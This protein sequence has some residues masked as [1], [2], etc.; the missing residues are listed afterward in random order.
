MKIVPVLARTLFGKFEENKILP[1]LFFLLVSCC[2][3]LLQALNEKYETDV[4]FR[5]N[6][7]GLPSD[8]EIDGDD[9]Y[10]RVRL[11]DTGTEL[12]FYKVKGAIPV[13]VDFG[14]FG[15]RDGRLALPLSA[16]ERDVKKAVSAST[17]LSGMLQDTLFID[18]KRGTMMLPV[19]LDGVIDA[20]EGFSVADVEIIPSKVKV[21][22]TA[23]DMEGLNNVRTE[24]VIKKYLKGS[25]SFKADVA[26]FGLM[27]VEPGEVDV[28]VTVYPLVERTVRVPVSYSGFPVG[29]TKPLPSEIEVS[30]KVPEPDADKMT[31]K[32]FVVSLDYRDALASNSRRAS[33]NVL[34]TSHKVGNMI[35]N[36]S[37]VNIW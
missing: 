4:A 30:F 18:V 7:K 10:F 37:Y 17:S 12:A 34:S 5:V 15:S 22:A 23:A 6:V 36:P 28:Y 8:L 19:E 24:Y 32:D 35:T 9:L 29:Y 13:D 2:L 33:F 20:A 14:V 16:L 11:R 31:P 27:T 3:W 25:T 21:M 26:S 1:F